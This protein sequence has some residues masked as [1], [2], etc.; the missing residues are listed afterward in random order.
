MP[1]RYGA[2]RQ[3][4]RRIGLK[5]AKSHG[6]VPQWLTAGGARDLQLTAVDGAGQ[7]RVEVVGDRLQNFLRKGES[8][9]VG[10][11]TTV[12]GSRKLRIRAVPCCFCQGNQEP[13]EPKAS[14]RV[15]DCRSVTCLVDPCA[16]FKELGKLSSRMSHL[17]SLPDALDPPH[18]VADDSG[19]QGPINAGLQGPMQLPCVAKE[20][21]LTPKLV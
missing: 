21:R 8:T 4:Q 15:R 16:S 6:R 9:S 19:L 18:Q 10:H 5:G 17:L 1:S 7:A 3:R 14:W 12:A 20:S 2:P 11:R 13:K